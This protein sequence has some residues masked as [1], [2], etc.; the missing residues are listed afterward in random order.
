MKFGDKLTFR[1]TVAKF[2]S[3][4]DKNLT[5]ATNKTTTSKEDIFGN[6]YSIRFRVLLNFSKK[7]WVVFLSIFQVY[8]LLFVFFG[9]NV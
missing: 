2:I 3:I 6:M 1:N 5:L 4:F 7:L 9:M 8:I